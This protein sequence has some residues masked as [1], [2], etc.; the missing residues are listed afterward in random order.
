[1]NE[2]AVLVL[3]LAA[4][5][6][7]HRGLDLKAIA[8]LKKALTIAPDNRPLLK[9]LAKLFLRCGMKE[10]AI[11]H[12]IRAALAYYRAGQPDKAIAICRK[13]VALDPSSGAARLALAELMV[14]KGA[15]NEARRSFLSA[16][17]IF[18][19]RGDVKRALKAY[20][21]VASLQQMKRPEP[22]GEET[23][24]DILP[25]AAHHAAHHTAI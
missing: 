16:A 11:R 2:A 3:S 18:E 4:D 13:L 17:A 15:I 21:R 23:G 1:M 8:V 9:R 14:R 24:F 7:I 6:L 20:T 25:A 5:S 12:C 22:G 10:E 19:N